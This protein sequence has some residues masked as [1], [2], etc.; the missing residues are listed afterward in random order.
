[1]TSSE[2]LKCPEWFPDKRKVPLQVLIPYQTNQWVRIKN[3]AFKCSFNFLYAK[4][5]GDK[6]GV[7][8]KITCGWK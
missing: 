2:K 4:S 3:V 8:M 6:E 1:M 7:M 5:F